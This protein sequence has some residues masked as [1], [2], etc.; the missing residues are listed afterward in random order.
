MKT[1]RNL[2]TIA[3][4]MFV[5]NFSILAFYSLICV[6]TTFRV[7]ATLGAHDFLNSVR[8]IPHYPWQMPVQSL[9]LYAMLCVISFFK[10]YRPVEYFP[11]RV[12]ICVAEIALC[13]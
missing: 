1:E 11:L 13:A 3:S 6:T 2:I 4:V 7:C 8:Q 9:S 12:G 5:L 10:F